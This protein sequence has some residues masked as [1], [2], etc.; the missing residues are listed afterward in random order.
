MRRP[1]RPK[2]ALVL[3][4]TVLWV[5]GMVTAGV[6]MWAF[7]LRALGVFI[8]MEA[9]VYFSLVAFTTLGFGDILLPQEWRLLAGM[10][11]V[12]ARVAGP[13]H[14]VLAERIVA[15]FDAQV[16][17]VEPL[18]GGGQRLVLA[19]VDGALPGGVARAR[20]TLRGAAAPV[21]VGALR[22]PARAISSSEAPDCINAST[23]S[24]AVLSRRSGESDG[25]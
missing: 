3:G 11:A 10:A 13:A 25:S 23:V 16:A 12:E 24:R 8:T 2:L 9:S 4:V 1:H 20:L 22:P 6:W 17:A 19:A 18:A 15:T 5:L 21:P 14:A 7:T